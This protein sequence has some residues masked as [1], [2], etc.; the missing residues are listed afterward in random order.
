VTRRIDAFEPVVIT[1]GQFHAG[2][3]RN[4]IPD[5]ATF[6]AT[7]RT[8]NPEVRDQLAKYCVQLCESIAAAYGL[9]VEAR[10]EQEYPVT[11]NNAEQHEF[12][13]R[14]V[15]EAYGD[16][17]FFEMPT[18][19]TGSEDFSRVLDRVPGT[20]VFLGACPT[21]EPETAP[22][23]HSPRAVFDDSVLSDGA[24]LLADLA[25]RRLA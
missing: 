19:I 8:F 3:K 4:I 20:F 5:E 23:N 25:Y 18:P 22:S 11:A 24:A 10:Y 9:T 7:I 16:E 1:V 14:A 17:R 6:E 21:D 13:A 15:R 2:T 12:V